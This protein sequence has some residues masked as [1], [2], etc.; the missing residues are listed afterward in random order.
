MVNKK[1][2][3]KKKT[4]KTKYSKLWKKVFSKSKWAKGK[5]DL[6][7][8][9]LYGVFL[10]ALFAFLLSFILYKKYIVDLPSV[11]ELENLNIA[12]SSTIYDREWNELYKIF[13]ENR[14]Y[15]PYE[16]IN[17]KMVN[18]IIAWEDKRFWDNPWVDLIWLV[19][20][21]VYKVIWKN[22]RIEWTSTLT[23]Q[24]IRNTIITNERKIE[25]KI[26]EIYLSYKL[27]N[28]VSKEKILELYLNKIAYWS[29]AHGI[30]QAAKT[31]F[32]VK[33]SELGILESSILASLPKWPTYYSPYNHYDRLVGYPYTYASWDEEN[34]QK[35]ISKKT[36]DL[37][38]VLLDEFK[39]FIGWLKW[40]ELSESKI[41][42]CGMTQDSFKANVSV[43][44]EWCSVLDYS[45]LLT[46][47]NS[48]RIEKDGDFL[49]YQTGR[50]DFILGRM[51]EDNYIS[52][53]E[54]K[55]AILK[56]ILLEFNIARDDI[57][58][59]HFV[60]YVKDY[61]EEKYWKDIL[62]SGGFQIYTTIDPKLQDKAEEI[63]EAR[64]K[65]NLV[66]FNANNAAMLSLDNEN[67][68]ILAM[69]GWADYFNTEIDG[70]NNMMTSRLQ[71]WSTF[72]PFVYSM[73]LTN[74]RVWAKTPVYDVKTRFP[75]GYIPSNFDGK[76]IGKM[77]I[78]KA[79]NYSRNIPAIK[80]FYLAGR[81]DEVLKFMATLWVKSLDTFKVEFSE[82]FGREY[83]YGSPLALGTWEMTG[84]ELAR[85]Y[86]V[87]ANLWELKDFTPI[88]KIVDS[89][90]V[91]I[92]WEEEKQKWEQVIPAKQAY[93]IN[94][95]LSDTESRPAEW[96]SYL[97]LP[98]R[99]TAA[100]TWT[101]TK[102]Y[103]IAGKKYIYPRNLWTVQYTPQ[104]TT[105]A[106]AWNTDGTQLGP[107]W[108]GLEWAGSIV[109]SFMRYAHAGKSVK[110]WNQPSWISNVTISELSWLLPSDTTLNSVLTS[111]LFINAPVTYDDSFKSVEVDAFCNGLI[112]TNT[113]V[114]AV[115]NVNIL[116]LRS[117]QP[118][119]SNW[120][121]PVQEWLKENASTA[122]S[123]EKLK[124]YKNI[125]FS[126]NENTCERPPETN[127]D[128]IVKSTIIP[129]ETFQ[130]GNN[131]IELGYQSNNRIIALDV[132]LD[133]DKIW[134]ITL[135]NKTRGLYR[136]NIVI[137]STYPEWDYNLSLRVID[138]YY[139]S[140][141]ET[142]KI[143]LYKKDKIKPKVVFKDLPTKLEIPENETYNLK[144]IIGEKWTLNSINVS[145]DGRVIARWIHWEN[146]ERDFNF[147]I[148]KNKDLEPG[149]HVI[150]IEAVDGAFN[151]WSS[152]VVFT[153]TEKKDSQAIFDSIQ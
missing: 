2:S 92:E 133:Q 125:A 119:N 128:I 63:V 69:V 135:K 8:I 38:V 97:S 15:I 66:N 20:A 35:I 61:L 115:R 142:K 99:V 120:E 139:E 145:I 124:S 22:D 17:Q 53:D 44:N 54:Y 23:Q 80:M 37:N 148:N 27:T 50:K 74:E 55:N 87:F 104:I 131:Y 83:S 75:W 86:S 85:A 77:S 94:N 59:P 41:L 3:F 96:N 84:L 70:N 32:W 105:V 11:K 62:E 81:E 144:G 6:L 146:E 12:Q 116:Q 153:I 79:L 126:L 24:L 28:W 98:W 71:P 64:A 118:A 138:T 45:D 76:F 43:D 26:K 39:S 31:F 130:Y 123:L 114:A 60:F 129:G 101:S 7:K 4:L 56:S 102:Q 14:T 49:E 103:K 108:N 9:A 58:Y 149:K 121:I 16:E 48:I 1:S 72:K 117:L 109:N 132:L 40:K 21:V 47:L 151:K 51:L 100:K 36:E 13:K 141:V 110:R 88:L 111:S 122:E 136:G 147:I 57:K 52:F 89:N 143:T 106:W 25:R 29:N 107:K 137:P 34:I 5:R 33:A 78:S 46:F 91:V 93:L 152:S 42:I 82:K 140:A 68:E 67:G 73:A 95:I 113:P 150:S 127:S 65:S 10:M 112:S 90:G 30:E 19:R 18:A 134:E